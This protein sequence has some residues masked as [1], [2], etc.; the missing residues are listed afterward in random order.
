MW[1]MRA[2]SRRGA[3]WLAGLALA[4]APALALA[5][6]DLAALS[7]LERGRWRIA[8]SDPKKPTRLICLRDPMMLTQVEHGPARCTR[9]ILESGKAGGTVQYRC[10]GH[11][12]GHTR[13]VVETP[14]IARID[15]QGIVDG[16]PFAWRAEA[17][18]VGTC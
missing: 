11:G 1:G 13:I 17:R 14:R 12:F 15:T 10:A 18:R 4:G 6:S 8:E 16:S 7:Q 3:L 9:Q 2:A 5:V